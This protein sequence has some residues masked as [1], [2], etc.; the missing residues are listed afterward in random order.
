[1]AFCSLLVSEIN[2]YD[3]KTTE[4]EIESGAN[5]T[6]IKDYKKT[7]VYKA[8]VVFEEFVRKLENDSK[9]RKIEESG[10]YMKCFHLKY[11]N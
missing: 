7:S 4:Q 2:A 8:V 6:L 11:T 1:M 5:K 9:G 10:M 3:A